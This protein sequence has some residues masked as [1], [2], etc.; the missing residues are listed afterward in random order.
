MA[1]KVQIIFEA[2]NKT[3]DDF[4]QV[5]KGLG[6]LDKDL[7]EVDKA[8]AKAGQ[9]LEGMSRNF[10]ASMAG[11]AIG[12]AFGALVR[13]IYQ[14]TKEFQKLEAS[15]ETVTG[16]AEAADAAFAMI[17]DFASRTPYQLDQVVGAFIKLQALGLDPSKES[18]QSYGNTASAMGKDLNQMIE[19]V[20]DAATGEFERLKEFGI[21]SR[22]EGKQVT[23]TFQGVATTVRN[24]ASAIEGY[25]RK[26]GEVQFAGAMERQM[27]T[28]GGAISNLEDAYASLL[29]KMGEDSGLADTLTESVRGLTAAIS[30]PAFTGALVTAAT[31]ISKIGSAAV[32]AVSD[33]D[34]M[35]RA[36]AIARAGYGSWRDILMIPFSDAATERIITDFDKMTVQQ[37]SVTEAIAR[38][39]KEI[40]DLKGSW[41]FVSKTDQER[42]D[43]LKEGLAYLE[44]QKRVI[45]GIAA[46]AGTPADSWLTRDR[47]APAPKNSPPAATGGE[48]E[49]ERKKRLAAADKEAAKAFK[50]RIDE[51]RMLEDIRANEEEKHSDARL[52]YLGRLQREEQEA[53]QLAEASI[54]TRL[55]EVD[56]AERLRTIS[57]GDAAA[58]RLALQQ[59]L[60]KVQ[61]ESLAKLNKLGD[62]SAWYAQMSAIN[63]TR[64][65]LVDLIDEMERLT[66]SL[67]EGFT[68]GFEDFLA[69]TETVF[70]TGVKLA[71]DSAAAMDNTFETLF[72]DAFRGRVDSL[73]SYWEMFL[74]EIQRSMA[75]SLANDASSRLLD[76]GMK[77]VGAFAGGAGGGTAPAGGGAEFGAKV[78]GSGSFSLGT[79]AP[80]FHDGGKF[81]PTFHFGGLAGDEGFAVLKKGERTFDPE[82]TRIVDNLSFLA[83]RFKTAE[84]QNREESS[85]PVIVNMSVSAMDA[86]SFNG[87]I[88][89]NKEAIAGAVSAARSNNVR[90]TR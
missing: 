56:I 71:T 44:Q 25:L 37:R 61:E 11:L 58:E 17:E 59:E 67:T 79:T 82:H 36:I 90:G 80:T 9:R 34:Q 4:A 74:V 70:E 24:E 46:A 84:N 35:G 45:D 23:F 43:Y 68:R 78:L 29:R 54:K 22:S 62:A 72:F 8:S 30:D 33:L 64:M 2:L 42:A 13:G 49:D 75:Q 31:L 7:R 18:L 50:A 12:V 6:R 63:A 47:G 48:T 3:N 1:N 53:Q 21:K 10:R 87:Y 83:E 69:H 27:N 26:L 57:R 14:T 28:L 5:H 76:L 38:T 41:G 16:S 40:E 66:G 39:K 81:V 73:R 89:Q 77:V 32:G 55:A 52:I 85:P 20:A 65:A 19:A 88:M 60:L 51:A 86:R 15:L